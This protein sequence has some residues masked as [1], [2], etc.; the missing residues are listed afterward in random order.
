MPDRVKVLV[1]ERKQNKMRI[2]DLQGLVE[3]LQ[4]RLFQ[5]ERKTSVTVNVGKRQVNDLKSDIVEL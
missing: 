2:S 1:N 3:D 4:T 5:A